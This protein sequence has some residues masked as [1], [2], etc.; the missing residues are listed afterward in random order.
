MKNRWDPAF[1]RSIK[2][3]IKSGEPKDLVIALVD[4]SC[5][6]REWCM[7]CPL[8]THRNSLG[9]DL[10]R[11]QHS[12]LWS[13]TGHCS[14]PLCATESMYGNN[15]LSF[16]FITRGWRSGKVQRAL[17]LSLSNGFTADDWLRLMKLRCTKSS[18]K[19]LKRVSQDLGKLINPSEFMFRF[20]PIWMNRGRE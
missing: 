16:T 12:L 9:K 5:S 11:S 1:D 2:R 3:F 4:F 19:N 18:R 8:A 6:G 17:G 13:K 15:G 20:L 14:I 7:T 10:T